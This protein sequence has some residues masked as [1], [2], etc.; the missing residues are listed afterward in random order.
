MID[1]QTIITNILTMMKTDIDYAR[2]ALKQYHAML[3]W[4]DLLAGV[5]DAMKGQQ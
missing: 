1:R 4:M 2:F 3:P 5:R